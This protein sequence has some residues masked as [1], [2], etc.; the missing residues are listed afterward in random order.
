MIVEC[1]GI[2][3]FPDINNGNYAMVLNYYQE[4]NLRDYLR[5]NHPKLTSNNR[6]M[7][8]RYLC[9]SLY[10]ADCNKT[11]Q[12]EHWYYQE[13]QGSKFSYYHHN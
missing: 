10:G 12:S 8:F 3:K 11:R 5:K 7:I 4:G 2:T 13:F 6:I 1:Y 9:E